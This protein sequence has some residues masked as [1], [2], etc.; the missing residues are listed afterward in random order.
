MLDDAFEHEVCNETD[1]QRVV[2]IIDVERP[3]PL[4]A[5]LL[6]RGRFRAVQLTAYVLDARRNMH[7]WE[8]RFEAAVQ[9][10]DPYSMDTEPRADRRHLGP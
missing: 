8:D 3:P 2:L 10:A 6:N 5:R 1:E 7:S 4:P 9:R